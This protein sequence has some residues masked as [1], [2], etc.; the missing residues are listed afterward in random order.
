[1]KNDQNQN[2]NPGYL[3][4]L[5]RDSQNYLS[6]GPGIAKDKDADKDQD[7]EKDKEGVLKCLNCNE[8]FDNLQELSVHMMITKHFEKFTNITSG[9]PIGASSKRSIGKEVSTPFLSK[10]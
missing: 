2:Q 8:S 10:D 9:P 6:G 4:K 5:L 3:L 7:K 1:M